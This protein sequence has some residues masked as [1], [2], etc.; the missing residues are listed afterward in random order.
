MTARVVADFEHVKRLDI[1]EIVSFFNMANRIAEAL[2]VDIEAKGTFH[3][4]DLVGLRDRLDDLAELG[5]TALW[6]TP[7][8][9]Q[10]DGF[11]TG[12]GFP[13]WGYHGYWADDFYS[14]DPRFGTVGEML[15]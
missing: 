2:N 12:A 13:D 10:I 6:I 11:V 5:I 9:K 1:V 14:L 7:V 4:G 3:G 15:C 8:V